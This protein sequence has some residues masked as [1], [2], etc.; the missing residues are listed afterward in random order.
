[1]SD[2]RRPVSHTG[3]QGRGWWLV[4]TYD[5]HEYRLEITTTAG[6]EVSISLTEDS[7]QMLG[8]WLSSGAADEVRRKRADAQYLRGSRRPP[9]ES[10]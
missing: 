7:A 9:A 10:S 3:I 1:M 5:G 8:L 2:S 6:E 4:G